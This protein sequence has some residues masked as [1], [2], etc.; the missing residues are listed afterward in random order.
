MNYELLIIIYLYCVTVWINKPQTRNYCLY[1]LC[2]LIGS[3][4]DH[5]SLYNLSSHLGVGIGSFIFDFDLIITCGG[6]LA[7]LAYHM[8]ESAGKT[9]IIHKFTIWYSLLI[10]AQFCSD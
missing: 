10:P 5:I 4:L 6:R 7:H 8:H 1:C 9:S 2:G 3:A